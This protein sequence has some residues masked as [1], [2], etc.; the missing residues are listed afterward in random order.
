MTVISTACHLLTQ[1][2]EAGYISVMALKEKQVY[3]L[4]FLKTAASFWKRTNLFLGVCARII[5][6]ARERGQ[7]KCIYSAN[8]PSLGIAKS[9]C[10]KQMASFFDYAYLNIH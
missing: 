6:S 2:W 5:T 3:F 8:E 7:L 9:S 1:P 4:L 10:A